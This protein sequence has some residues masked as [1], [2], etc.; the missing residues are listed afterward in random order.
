MVVPSAFHANEGATGVRRLLLEQASIEWCL[1]FENRRKLFEIHS[2][3]KFALLVA[4]KPGPTKAIKCA[5]YLNDF[6]HPQGDS[7]LMS[8]DTRFI[9]RSGRQYATLLELRG[10]QELAVARR[11]FLSHQRFSEWARNRGVVLGRELNMTDD[12]SRFRPMGRR[13][14]NQ[15]LHEGKTIHQFTDRWENRPRYAVPVPSLKDKPAVLRNSMYFRAACR[16]IA[17]ATN[18]RT[19]IATVLPPGTV[20]GHTINVERRPHLR[21]NAAALATVVLMNSFA[22]DW[23]VRQKTASHVSL[24]ILE[25]IPAPELDAQAERFLVHAALRLCCNHAQFAPLWTEQLGRTWREPTPSASW[26]VL[27]GE[28]RWHV[29]AEADGLIAR[30]YGLTRSHYECI[31]GSFSHKAFPAMPAL[32]LAA[33]DAMGSGGRERFL[34]ERDPYWDLSSPSE[35]ARPLKTF[36]MAALVADGQSAKVTTPYRGRADASPGT[37]PGSG[38]PPIRRSQ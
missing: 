16:E 13:T 26:P 25:G 18:E 28:A 14:A 5:F 19:A 36:A 10:C 24:F 38:F 30:A 37:P 17:S 32:C 29:R 8:Y 3:F 11:M 20:C 1:S 21:P 22:F 9:A 2:G 12:A 31:L 33:F 6:I 15:I 23:M 4:R 34:R 27:S 35:N 7:R